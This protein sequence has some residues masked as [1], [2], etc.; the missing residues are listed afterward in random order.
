MN[1]LDINKFN[2]KN[3]TFS[4]TIFNFF[5]LLL[6]FFL[7]CTINVC[8]WWWEMLTMDCFLRTQYSVHGNCLLSTQY[9]TW[10][11]IK[12]MSNEKCIYIYIYIK[13]YLRNQSVTRGQP[14]A[15]VIFRFIFK[16]RNP[17]NHQYCAIVY[18]RLFGKHF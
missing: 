6:F 14:I 17:H 13:Y 16:F 1:P 8:I 18:L 5:S 11:V 15:R 9:S 4:W 7:F 3:F 2:L 10:N 12:I